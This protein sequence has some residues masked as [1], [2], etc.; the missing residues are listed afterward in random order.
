MGTPPPPQ[1]EEVCER[2]CPDQE[3]TSPPGSNTCTEGTFGGPPEPTAMP[4]QNL[5]ESKFQTM[6][7][8]PCTLEHSV[9]FF[10]ML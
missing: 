10:A 2:M 7:G 3:S 4:E 8:W 9:S 1:G 6:S 5:A